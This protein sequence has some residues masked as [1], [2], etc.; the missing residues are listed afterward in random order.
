LR[1]HAWVRDVPGNMLR[2]CSDLFCFD[3]ASHAPATLP[4]SVCTLIE[5]EIEDEIDI[6]ERSV[7]PCESL[8]DAD[9]SEV[10]SSDRVAYELSTSGRAL[11]LNMNAAIR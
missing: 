3:G 9:R 5:D 10:Y 7:D 6:L 8:R 4:C 2:T 11:V 1:I